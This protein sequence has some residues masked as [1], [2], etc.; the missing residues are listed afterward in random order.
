MDDLDIIFRLLDYLKITDISICYDKRGT[1]RAKDSDGNR[2]AG[3]AFFR[4]ITEEALCFDEAGNLQPGQ[5]V[6][7]QHSGGL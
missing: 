2:W 4:F 6:P 5:Y 7:R 3:K 1:I